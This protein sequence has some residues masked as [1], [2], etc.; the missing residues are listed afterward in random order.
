VIIHYLDASA[1][2]K[3]YAREAGSE[4]LADLLNGWAVF[5]CAS[6]G[7]IEVLAALYRR[8][9]GG[10]LRE[11]DFDAALRTFQ[12]DR[13]QIIEV[14]LTDEVMQV[15][16]DVVHRFALRGAD[17]VHLASALVV[18]KRFEGETVTVVTSDRELS[19]AAQAAGFIVLDPVVE[20]Q[21]AAGGPQR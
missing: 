14:Q 21:R 2:V 20:E 16:D 7:F 9:K 4:W 1:W 11:P 19:A 17:T 15:A 3:R 10:D 5:T 18:G 13:R 8:R 12:E 6:L